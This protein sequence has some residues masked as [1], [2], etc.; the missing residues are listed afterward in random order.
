MNK[1]YKLRNVA[2]K[3][4][5]SKEA[6][7]NAVKRLDLLNRGGVST[8]Y[9]NKGN[10]QFIFNEE[11]VKAIGDYLLKNPSKIYGIKKMAE[12]CNTTEYKLYTTM[13]KYKLIDDDNII[14]RKNGTYK[15]MI[16]DDSVVQIIKDYV[17]NDVLPKYSNEEVKKGDVDFMK[18]DDLKESEN[19]TVDDVPF[20][21]T[22]LNDTKN[23]KENKTK[24]E[25]GIIEISPFAQSDEEDENVSTDNAS[26]GDKNNEGTNKTGKTENTNSSSPNA[27]SST[28]DFFLKSLST[29]KH[30]YDSHYTDEHDHRYFHKGEDKLITT[31]PLIPLMQDFLDCFYDIERI[32]SDYNNLVETNKTKHIFLEEKCKKYDNFILKIKKET[33]EEYISLKNPENY[34]L[35]DKKTFD[36]LTL[37]YA[38]AK[39]KELQNSCV[40]KTEFVEKTE[41]TKCSINFGIVMLIWLIILT[42]LLIFK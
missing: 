25:S 14:A 2:D 11:A 35:L 16:F 7:L 24:K 37:K 6:I 38:N 8:E 1:T 29:H 20:E 4:D 40:N 13:Q 9:D 27:E 39:I 32:V 34:V 21:N 36:E 41:K 26:V 42:V 17:E 3:F 15:K 28:M 5:V 33:A 23:D 10:K 12:E 31:A 19:I 22:F 18:S 30:F